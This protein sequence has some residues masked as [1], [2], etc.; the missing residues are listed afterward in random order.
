MTVRKTLLAAGTA[1]LMSAPAWA[2]PGQALSH[3]AGPPSSTPNDLNNPGATHRSASATDVLED[4]AQAGKPGDKGKDEGPGTQS[5]SNRGHSHKC[6][7]HR[8][9]YVASATVESW[10]LT[11]NGDGTFRGSVT[12]HITHTNHHAA[13]DRPKTPGET[14]EYKVEKV[15]LTFGLADTNSDGSVGLDDLAKGDR[16]NV[17]GKITTIAKKC[18]QTGF[19]ATTTIRRI[20]FHAPSPS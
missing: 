14:H 17:L 18:S 11:P 7:P 1:A 20:I 10:S 5:P 15:H 12:V 19:T 6:K 9:G 16:V 2:L 3:P 13:S 8:V 4:R